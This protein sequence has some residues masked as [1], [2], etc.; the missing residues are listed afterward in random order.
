[1]TPVSPIIK[2]LILNG[3]ADYEQQPNGGFMLAVNGFFENGVFIPEKPLSTISIR[4]RQRAVLNIDSAGEAAEESLARK[5]EAFQRFTRYLGVLP[6]DFDY[7]LELSEYRNER[8]G[9]ID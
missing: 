1:L 9:H 7:R 8:Y 3:L 5:Q 6:A 4:G 2:F